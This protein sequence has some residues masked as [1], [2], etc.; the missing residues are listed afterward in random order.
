MLEELIR[1]NAVVL[2][3]TA[4]LRYSGEV[5]T[6]ELDGVSYEVTITLT[7]AGHPNFHDLY[8]EANNARTS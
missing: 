3:K 2:D 6:V 7:R 4:S 8:T 1:R 5:H